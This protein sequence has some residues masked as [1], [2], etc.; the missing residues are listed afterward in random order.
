MLTHA[1]RANA[2]VREYVTAVFDSIPERAGAHAILL[3]QGDTPMYVSKYLS[4]V[5]GLR[6]DV[7]ERE[8]PNTRP[9]TSEAAC[10]CLKRLLRMPYSAAKLKM[11]GAGARHAWSWESLQHLVLYIYYEYARRCST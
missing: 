10:Q 9:I 5:E 7:T 4:E 6:P 11:L 1:Q 8:P 3:V 2:V